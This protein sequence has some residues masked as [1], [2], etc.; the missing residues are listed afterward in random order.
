MAGKVLIGIGIHTKPSGEY[1]IGTLSTLNNILSWK[2]TDHAML[3]KVK[4]LK[5]KQFTK[6]DVEKLKNDQHEP[7]ATKTIA[8]A[9]N[10]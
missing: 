8:Y 7:T 6:H 1:W 10:G 9:L 2:Q 3:K 4:P 5:D